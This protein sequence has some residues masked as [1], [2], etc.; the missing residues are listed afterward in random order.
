VLLLPFDAGRVTVH[1]WRFAG[2]VVQGC[3]GG[4]VSEVK[5][6]LRVSGCVFRLSLATT[7]GDG[8]LC[9]VGASEAAAA[10]G[11]FIAV[12]HVCSG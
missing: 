6:T 12:A 1:R 7:L 5:V 11:S 2:G 9:G 10:G 8:V 4:L 3:V